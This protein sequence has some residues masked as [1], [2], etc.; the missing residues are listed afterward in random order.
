MVLCWFVAP[1]LIFM[2][3]VAM[4]SNPGAVSDPAYL[5]NMLPIDLLALG[6]ELI[7]FVCFIVGLFRALKTVDFL[8][9][10]EYARMEGEERFARR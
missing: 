9:R 7:G 1:A 3:G 4:S 5:K 2:I 10:R 8:G 6:V